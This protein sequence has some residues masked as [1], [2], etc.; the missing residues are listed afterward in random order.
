MDSVLYI[1]L[2]VSIAETLI[3]RYNFYGR[4]IIAGRAIFTAFLKK[5]HSQIEESSGIVAISRIGIDRRELE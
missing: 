1:L 3:I 2:I 4:R 5:C